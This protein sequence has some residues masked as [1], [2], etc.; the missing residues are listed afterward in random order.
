MTEQQIPTQASR[1][2][3]T[4]PRTNGTA[5]APRSDAMTGWVRFGGV[6]MTIVGGFGIL[7]GLFALFSPTY[8]TLTGAG[9]LLFDLTAWGW[10]HI[11]LGILVLATGMSLLGRAPGWARGV[12]IT[13]L[14][15]NA[16][17]QLAYLPAYPI[18][19]LVLI[20]LDIVVIY[21]LMV[22]WGES[23]DY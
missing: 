20:T 10:V 15:I 19:S 11:V 3:M 23:T 17:V 7:Q 21:A 2:S 13:L 4:P 6:V 12:G 14:A 18:W 9:V 5:A 1:A 22:T 8:V 16:I